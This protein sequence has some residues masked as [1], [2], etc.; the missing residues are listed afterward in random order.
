MTM[1]DL[2]AVNVIWAVLHGYSEDSLGNR[3][4]VGHYEEN[5]DAFA[6]QWAEICEAMSHI[7]EQLKA[8]Q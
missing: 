7:S 3:I 8:A 2:K 4:G 1:T 5:D 6:D